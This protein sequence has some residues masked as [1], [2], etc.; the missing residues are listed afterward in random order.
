MFVRSKHSNDQVYSVEE[1]PNF[2]GYSVAS[3]QEYAEDRL[4]RG[5]PIDYI[6][7]TE[8]GEVKRIYSHKLFNIGDVVTMDGNTLTID[9]ITDY[10]GEDYETCQSIASEYYS[11]S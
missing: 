9:K 11:E 5:L 3:S 2:G 4:K 7:T 10:R 6:C 1:F 8:S